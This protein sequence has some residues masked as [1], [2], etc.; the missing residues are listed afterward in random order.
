MA[1]V[2]TEGDNT[3]YIYNNL[4]AWARYEMTQDPIDI[5]TSV[6][7]HEWLHLALSAIDEER[8]A[9]MLDIKFGQGDDH[10]AEYFGM[11]KFER[12]F[13]PTPKSRRIKGW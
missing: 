6:I 11:C 1:Y 2:Y 12:Y 9:V 7:S 10:K 8:A 3:V 4:R 5:M 13:R